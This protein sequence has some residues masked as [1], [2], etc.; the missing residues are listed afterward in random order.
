MGILN[1][2]FTSQLLSVALDF[3][4]D[5]TFVYCSTTNCVEVGTIEFTEFETPFQKYTAAKKVH[6]KE[7]LVFIKTGSDYIT[8]KK[9]AALVAA[10]ADKTVER[11]DNGIRYC[12]LNLKDFVYAFHSLTD[13]LLGSSAPVN[14]KIF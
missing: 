3:N 5:V 13:N 7:T 2:Y 8:Y 4:L 11:T 1:D 14:V 12:R 9:D 6:G 10:K